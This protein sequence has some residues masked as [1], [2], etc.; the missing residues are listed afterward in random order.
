MIR[1]LQSMWVFTEIWL[2]SNQNIF[3][4]YI[5]LLFYNF[6]QVTCWFISLINDK[7]F[8]RSTNKMKWSLYILLSIEYIIFTSSCSKDTF[9]TKGL[10]YTLNFFF[11]KTQYCQVLLTNLDNAELCKSWK[12]GQ[13]YLFIDFTIQVINITFYSHPHII[14]KISST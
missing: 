10:F 3:I 5:F 9:Q 6:C 14:N 4:Q 1:Q 13:Q 8:W 2:R 12:F 7:S 11:V